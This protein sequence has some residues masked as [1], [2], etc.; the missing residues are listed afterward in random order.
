MQ[1]CGTMLI[2]TLLFA[3]GLA[4]SLIAGQWLVRPVRMTNPFGI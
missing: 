1:E 4:V 3:G 2:Q